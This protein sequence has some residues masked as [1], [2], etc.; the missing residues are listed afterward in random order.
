MASHK[1]SRYAE[2]LDTQHLAQYLSKLI[3]DSGKWLPD[4][5]VLPNHKWSDDVTKVPEISW[6]D[7]A[8]YLIDSPSVYTKEK[9]KAYTL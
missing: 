2:K 3:L 6:R 1:F 4:P 8:D 9:M 7:V 5:F